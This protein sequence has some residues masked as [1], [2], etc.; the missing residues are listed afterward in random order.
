MSGQG[1]RIIILTTYIYLNF[2]TRT[3]EK[4]NMGLS[5]LNAS[6]VV[7]EMHKN[8]YD[9]SLLSISITQIREYFDLNPYLV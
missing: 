3:V 5:Q 6:N 1:P 2:R 8:P 4:Y 7:D 9:I